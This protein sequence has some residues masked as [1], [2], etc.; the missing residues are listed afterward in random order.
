MNTSGQEF[1]PD[2]SHTWERLL[3]DPHSFDGL[4]ARQ[5]AELDTNRDLTKS[6]QQLLCDVHEETDADF[7][8]APLRCIA[9]SQKRMVGMMAKV[10]LSNEKLAAEN[11]KLQKRVLWLTVIGVIAAGVAVLLGAVQ[12]AT[13]I[14]AICKH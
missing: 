11:D 5:R 8:R 10:A 1:R 9:H 12:A 14:I 7:D 3:F 13:G 4:N 2:P 6:I